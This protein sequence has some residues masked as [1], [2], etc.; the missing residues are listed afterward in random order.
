MNTAFEPDSLDRRREETSSL[1]GLLRSL[2]HAP[3]NWG[4]EHDP[5]EEAAS[6]PASIGPYTILGTLGRG[7]MGVVYAAEDRNLG[8]KVA[9]KVLPPEM[10]F[11]RTRMERLRREAQALAALSHPNVVTVYSLE[12]SD[13]IQFFTMELVEGRPLSEAIPRDGMDLA[14]LIKLARPIAEALI[15]AHRRGIIHRD[16]KPSNIMIGD[17]GEVK[18]LDFGLAKF[19]SPGSDEREEGSERPTPGR[20]GEWLT[21]NS[22]LTSP[23]RLQGTLPYMS[24]EQVEGRNVDLRTD[25]FAFGVILYELATGRR[26]FQGSSPAELSSE[27]RGATP[28]RVSD[29]RPGLPNGL[30]NIIERC[31]AKDCTNRF[32]NALDLGRELDALGA[33]VGRPSGGRWSRS[34]RAWSAIGAVTGVVLAVM[35]L[36]RDRGQVPKDVSSPR[37]TALVTWASDES[38]TRISPNREQISYI[39]NRDGMSN[40]WLQTL[41]D[42]AA[43]RLTSISSGAV[44]SSVWSA[45]GSEIAYLVHHGQEADLEITGTEGGPPRLRHRIDAQNAELLRWIGDRIYLLGDRL[46]WQFDAKKGQLERLSLDGSMRVLFGA[47]VRPDEKK[48]VFSSF[49]HGQQDLWISDLNGGA[50]TRLTNDEA[51]EHDPRW[52]DSD[53]WGVAF[54]S[55]R[56]GDFNLWRISVD[57]ESVDQLTFGGGQDHLEDASL[58]GKLLAVRRVGETAHVYRLDLATHRE[59]Q[60]TVD[61][62][63]DFWPSTGG[64][65]LVAFQRRGVSPEIGDHV[66]EAQ[67]LIGRLGESA[68][69]DPRRVTDNGFWPRLSPDGRWLTYLQ[70][71]TGPKATRNPAVLPEVWLRNL[72]TE[73]SERIGEA[74]ARYG[75]EPYPLGWLVQ[76]LVWSQDSREIYFVARNAKRRPEIR[77]VRLGA[78]KR[79]QEVVI[80]ADRSDERLLDPIPSYDHQRL[81]YVR[82]LPAEENLSRVHELELATRRDRLLYEV[83][84]GPRS[85]LRQLG[86]TGP[87]SV[88]VLQS[89]RN[90]DDTSRLTILELDRTGSKRILG[91]TDHAWL[92]TAALDS[93]RGLLYVTRVEGGIHNI[94]GFDVTT[95]IWARMTHNTLPGVTFSGLE[96]SARGGLVYA[97]QSRNNDLWMIRFNSPN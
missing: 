35:G 60:L 59:T 56:S 89:T 81:T 18:V 58:G 38:G 63:Q 93:S 12:E 90:A 37:Q 51:R 47:D 54:A 53:G 69:N 7:G 49:Q 87:S 24:P 11:D 80:S 31:L 52:L 67:V 33:S 39:S 74:F 10:T 88:L 4:Y 25:I 30:V 73:Q 82:Q 97:R 17:T 21:T 86:A 14:G 41:A 68:L 36:L 28:P 71:P 65:D 34:G 45:D 46:L 15:A 62:L 50:A 20:M 13:G 43:S 19:W 84:L 3:K 27:I 42:G 44:T 5:L 57:T 96:V 55:D 91:T 83:R 26:P 79:E 64:D 85:Q 22:W 61:S 78:A 6:Q 70:S 32:Q 29:L 77:R 75:V 9:L 48:L 2:A 72:S 94:F 23:G 1:D 95:R 92:A 16:L 40:L 66:G 76:N 8:R